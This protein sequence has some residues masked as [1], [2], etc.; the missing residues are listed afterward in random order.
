MRPVR[1]ALILCTLMSVVI[2][3]CALS[4]GNNPPNAPRGDPP[5]S[6]FRM[7]PPPNA[8][9]AK[10]DAAMILLRKKLSSAGIKTPNLPQMTWTQLDVP[11]RRQLLSS[12][13][14]ALSSKNSSSQ[15]IETAL[16]QASDDAN[17]QAV[18]ALTQKH[19]IDPR[20]LTEG[21]SDD[22]AASLRAYRQF[23]VRTGGEAADPPRSDDDFPSPRKRAPQVGCGKNCAVIN[24]GWPEPRAPNT[25]PAAI[26]ATERPGQQGGAR[27]SDGRRDRDFNPIGFLEV[28]IIDLPD[29][30]T[31]TGTILSPSIVLTAAHCVVDYPTNSLQVRL[32]TFVPKILD[33]CKRT[34]DARRRYEQCVDFDLV[35]VKQA[36]THSLYKASDST[37][38][39]AYLILATPRLNATKASIEFRDAPPQYI[40]LAGYGDNGLGGPRN[41]EMQNAIEVGWHEGG[42]LTQGVGKIGWLFST[43]GNDSATCHGDSGGPIYDGDNDGGPQDGQ[44]KVFAITSTGSTSSCQNFTVRNTN[45]GSA[46]VRTWLC[47][48]APLQGVISACL[49]AT[50]SLSSTSTMASASARRSVVSAK[51]RI[52]P[53]SAQI[54]ALEE[55][56]RTNPAT[57]Q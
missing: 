10:T 32:P 21:A 6:P 3:P 49:T 35:K 20:V 2:A 38:D 48:E 33:Q 52:P 17:K 4:Q 28:A 18:V 54:A 13:A 25:A 50:S 14:T 31:C 19:L 43:S 41:L 22:G 7:V 40:T 55:P 11:A 47:K 16:K 44:H 1:Y 45:L 27:A 39:V 53:G 34:L 57:L 42:A 29:G 5:E 46:A 23:L 15:E 30:G 56:N 51:G 8:P 9:S 24:P 26:D 37:N 36:V 12:Y